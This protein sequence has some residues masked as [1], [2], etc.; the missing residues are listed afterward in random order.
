M[1]SR[2]VLRASGDQFLFNLEAGNNEVI[3]TSERYTARSSALNGIEAVRANARVDA[4]YQR[5]TATSGEP[6]FVLRAPNNE[7]LGTSELYSSTQARN[8]GIDAVRE[9]APGAQVDDQ[10]RAEREVSNG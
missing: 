2:F 1:S 5:R 10:S 7:V 9:N 3:L 6:Y 4:Q 8:A